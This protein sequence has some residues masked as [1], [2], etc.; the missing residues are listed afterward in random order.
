VGQG[1]GYISVVNSIFV[2]ILIHF[3]IC[4]LTSHFLLAAGFEPLISQKSVDCSTTVPPSMASLKL[5]QLCLKFLKSRE[6]EEHVLDINAGKQVSY[7]A[8]DV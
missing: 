8:T 1:A 7:A 4:L 5:L 6:I 2:I 3:L